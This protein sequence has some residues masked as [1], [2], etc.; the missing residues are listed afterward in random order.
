MGS[1]WALCGFVGE[2]RLRRWYE[3]LGGFYSIWLGYCNFG[4]WLKSFFLKMCCMCN[5]GE[6]KGAR[7]YIALVCISMESGW[8]FPKCFV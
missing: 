7:N 6:G 5:T 8:K 2:G 4:V 3:N 1:M